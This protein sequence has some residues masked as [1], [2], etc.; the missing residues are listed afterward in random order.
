MRY[1]AVL[2][3]VAT[4]GFIGML[5]V[6]FFLS[7]QD[8]LKPADAIVV[9][10]GGE[11]TER[12]R[13]GVQLYQ[14]G[15]APTIVMSGAARDEGVSNAVA[16][17]QIAIELG[18]PDQQIIIEEQSQTTLENARFIQSLLEQHT[19][20]SIILVTSPYHQRRAYMSFRY[21]LGTD[22]IIM[23][24]SAADS[25]WRKNGWWRTGWGQ[26]LTWS[27]LQKVLYLPILF[28]SL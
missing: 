1:L 11:T 6:G 2:L 17:K 22:F 25:I 7:P 4:L 19:I 14:A 18:V 9:I 12:V 26:H 16:M 24:H 20:R 28:K 27:E 10:S 8:V 5:S 21:F 23:N 13:E 15:W 3:V